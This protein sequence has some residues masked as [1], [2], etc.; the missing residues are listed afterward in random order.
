MTGLVIFTPKEAQMV[1]SK[2]MAD[3]DIQSFILEGMLDV[4]VLEK[5]EKIHVEFFLQEK[6]KELTASCRELSFSTISYKQ[7]MELLKKT[8]RLP[9]S[10][11]EKIVKDFVKRVEH[12]SL[13]IQ[14]EEIIEERPTVKYLLLLE[15]LI[16][17]G[18]LKATDEMVSKK[19]QLNYRLI[20]G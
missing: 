14:F 9:G 8:I 2:W 3:E 18:Y 6:A 4:K 20:N 7:I 5:M 11:L 17:E 12:S 19:I 13:L 10:H 1:F 16:K 15:K